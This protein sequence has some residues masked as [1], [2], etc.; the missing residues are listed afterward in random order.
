MAWPM[1][2]PTAD[3]TA[4]PAAVDAIWANIPGCLGAAAGIPTADGGVC[5]GAGTWEG[6][7]AALAIGG[8]DGGARLAG[9]GILD[10]LLLLP[11][12]MLNN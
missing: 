5:I 9:G 2:W 1:V 11:L 3:P 7:G 6:G 8:G 4:T 10:V 12:G